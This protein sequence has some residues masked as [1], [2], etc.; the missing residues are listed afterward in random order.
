M[1]S[2]PQIGALG[3]Y[4]IAEC[5]ITPPHWFESYAGWYA[6][7]MQSEQTGEVTHSEDMFLEQEPFIDTPQYKT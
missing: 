3:G 5:E 4:G 1:E 7:G 6:I 2:N